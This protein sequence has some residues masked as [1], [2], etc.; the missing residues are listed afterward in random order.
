MNEERAG[1]VVIGL[2]NPIMGDDGVGIA[3]LERL[4]DAWVVPAAVELVDGG[5]W[6]LT[7]LPVL[8]SARRVLFLDAIRTGRPAGTAVTLRGDE[9]P[10]QVALK[11][12]QHQ[13]DLRE[14]LAVAQL[15]GT[16]PPEMVAVGL[17]PRTFELGDPM[18]PA[19]ADGIDRVVD[20]AVQQLRA[21]GHECAPA[22]V[23]PDRPAARAASAAA[24]DA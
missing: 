24:V 10:R 7:L 4:R 21:W 23:N 18:T 12:S 5:T 16:L 1:D 19:V 11:V 6:G 14:V 2:G 13:I 15:R 9:I 22:R 8:E 20:L 17:E 3:A